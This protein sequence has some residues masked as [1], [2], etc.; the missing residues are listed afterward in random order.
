MEH[1]DPNVNHVKWF[2]SFMPI[3]ST[4]DQ[5]HYYLASWRYLWMS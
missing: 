2:I 1:T 3:W 4:S 5:R